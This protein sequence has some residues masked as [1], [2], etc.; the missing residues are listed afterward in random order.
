MASEFRLVGGH[1]KA[2]SEFAPCTPHEYDSPLLR[3][4]R[5]HAHTDR[6]PTLG[7]SL[8][9]VECHRSHLAGYSKGLRAQTRQKLRITNPSRAF[10]LP[11]PDCHFS[12]WSTTRAAA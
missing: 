4:C 11:L 12:Y 6:H 1:T 9:R 2:L 3:R 5:D 10:Q 7:L 8:T